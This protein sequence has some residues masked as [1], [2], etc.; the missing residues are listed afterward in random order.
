M[1][2]A[3]SIVPSSTNGCGNVAGLDAKENSTGPLH[4]V[5]VQADEVVSWVMVQPVVAEHV[6]EPS[7]GEAEGVDAAG[8]SV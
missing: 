3:L 7:N 5:T 4:W 6:K 2:A 1:C 8:V